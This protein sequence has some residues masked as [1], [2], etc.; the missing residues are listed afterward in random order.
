MLDDLFAEH[1][2]ELGEMEFSAA[3]PARAN[4]YST[5]YPTG[6]YVYVIRSRYGFKIGKTVNIRERTRLFAVKLPFPVSLEH[7]AWF[8]DYSVAERDLHSMFSS[9]RLEGEWFDLGEADLA[10]IRTLGKP[11]SFDGF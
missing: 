2:P 11:A 6:G 3:P 10:R 1:F 9:K 7:C 4:A 5:A 8:D